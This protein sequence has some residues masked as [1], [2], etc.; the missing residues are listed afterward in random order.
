MK[1]KS[2]IHAPLLKFSVCLMA[3]IIAANHATPLLP[4]TPLLVATVVLAWIARRRPIA[5]SLLI[6][7]VFFYLGLL[8]DRQRVTP[9]SEDSQL[10]AVVM[11]EPAEKPKTL[12]MDLTLPQ[13]GETRRCYIWKDTLSRQIALGDALLVRLHDER[14]VRW[15]DWQHGGNG[16]HLLSRL[17]G[18]RLR[19]LLLRHRLLNR[20]RQM[21]IG[22]EQYAVLA[23]MTL[24]DKSALTNELRQTYSVT[25]ASHIL[26]LSGLH[27]GIIFF[28]LTALTG[29]RRSSWLVQL[30]LLLSIWAFVFLTGLAPGLIRSAIMLTVYAIFSFGGRSKMSVNVLCL[31]AIVMLLI[32]ADSL[33]DV[34]FQLSFASVFA[35]LL[36]MPLFEGFLAPDF[37]FRHPVLNRLWSLIAVSL[38]AQIGVAPLSAYYF[39]SFPTYFLLTNFVAIPA[40]TCILYGALLTLIFPPMAVVLGWVVQFLNAALDALSHLPMASISHLHPNVLQVCLCYVVIACFYLMLARLYATRRTSW[41]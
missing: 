7:A 12:M 32:N 36:F 39:G 11:S 28:L 16:L 14:F 40:A 41:Q 24:G 19:A 3:G 9:P 17:Q 10:E 37:R 26:A 5:Q 23:A 18:T 1:R 29:R 15:D 30:L 33:F 13:L 31:T 20:Y 27:L 2:Y 38:A 35:I 6:C 8:S 25:G 34:S 21:R 22:D 4:V